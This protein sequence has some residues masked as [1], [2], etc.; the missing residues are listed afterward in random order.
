MRNTLLI[1]VL[2]LLLA[3]CRSTKP[4]ATATTST[5][6]ANDAPPPAEREFRAA[7][8][9]TVANINWPSKPGLPVDSQQREAIALLDFLKAHHFNAVIFQVR[10]QADA[11]YQSALEPWSYYLTGMQ[12]KAPDP[13][14]DPLKFWTDE[15]H[16]RGL[17]LHVWLNPYRVHHPSGGPVTDSSLARRRPELVLPLKTS[18]Y[19]WFDPALP[20]T[21]EHS[22]AVV[23]DIVKRYDI[24]GVHF[25][26]YFYPYRDY[27][28]GEDFP[29]SASYAA[30]TAGGGKLARND[31]RRDAVNS[32]IANLYK[33]IKKEKREVKF[34]LSPFGIYRPGQP[35]TA[36][37]FDQYD[38]LYADAKLWLNK[39]WIDY[40][41]PQLYW[42][43]TRPQQSFPVLLGW[44]KGENTMGRHLWPGINVGTDTSAKN[45]TEVMNQLMISRGMLPD[46]KGVI[47]WSIGQV[48]KSPNM[49]NA[50]LNGPYKREA[51]VPASP[52]L[53][54]RKPA[55]PVATTTRREDAVN[56]SWSHPEAGD[57]FRW[58]IYMKHGNNWSYRILDA[59][60]RAYT[61]PAM[62]KGTNNQELKLSA[63][64]V[65]AVDR[66]GNESERKP[67]LLNQ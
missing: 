5:P 12:G 22:T 62:V 54:D 4:A 26:D 33:E 52:W 31:W 46:S 24:D 40:F 1:A 28:K 6:V 50:L 11:L 65:S 41:A 19:Y 35:E 60:E 9:A 27:N 3:A 66:S 7:W 30:Y 53:D 48:F 63:V 16:K 14:Y 39:G 45:V 13:F 56:V 55:A 32:F 64:S 57:V 15:A 34:G 2:G 44:W 58:V 8:V 61:V 49:A 37:C 29:D 17:E 43:I 67:I 10:P 47:H 59:G 42:P 51:L 25:D 21:K 18:G 23:L 36:C 20:G 38:I